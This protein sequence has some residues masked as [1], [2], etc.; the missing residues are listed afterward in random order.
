[1][2]D[3]GGKDMDRGGNFSWSSISHLSMRRLYLPKFLLL[4]N[5]ES[6]EKL[7]SFD[8]FFVISVHDAFLQIMKEVQAIY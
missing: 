3:N 5:T 6:S 7:P 8:H 1:M 2:R 4:Q